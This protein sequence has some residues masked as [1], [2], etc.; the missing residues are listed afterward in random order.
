MR[1]L[2]T[3][4][5]DKRGAMAVET[6]LALPVLLALSLGG[7]KASQLVAKRAELQSAAAEAETIILAKQP[8]TTAELDTIA[9]ILRTSTGLTGNAVTVS[10][11]Y[12][13]GT[14]ATTTATAGTC[15]S[16]VEWIYVRTQL[17]YTYVPKWVEWGVGNNVV[18]TVDRTA[19]VA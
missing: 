11:L 7:V 13:C 8:K 15:G 16:G 5:R 1:R 10:F 18:I 2:R 19:Q 17:T 14:T 4:L 9:A 3:F 6:A 12:R